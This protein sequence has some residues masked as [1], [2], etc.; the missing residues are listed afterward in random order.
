MT[1]GHGPTLANF[2]VF[3]VLAKFCS[4]RLCCCCVVV[5]CGSMLLCS[6]LLCSCS[7][8]LVVVF[9]LLCSCCCV[10]VVVWFCLVVVVVFG[11]RRTA[12]RRTAQNFALAGA[13]TRQPDSPHVH[14]SGHLRF[15]TPPKFNEKTPRET[16]KQR[17]GGGKGKTKREIWGPPPF[18]APTLSVMTAFGQTAFGQNRIWQ[19]KSE[20]G[21]FVFVTAFGQTAFGQN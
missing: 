3:S 11:L 12:L 6:M 9:L 5:L 14:I 4:W 10:L 21:Q 15:K 18:G 19:K 8:V 20:F 7:C 13:R 17:N 2:S 16:Q 1:L